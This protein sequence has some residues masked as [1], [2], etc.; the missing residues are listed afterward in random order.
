MVK[1]LK[2]HEGI[3]VDE[4]GLMPLSFFIIESAKTLLHEAKMLFP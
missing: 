3:D 4:G 2:F 1:L